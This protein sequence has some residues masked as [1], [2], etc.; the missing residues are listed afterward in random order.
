MDTLSLIRWFFCGIGVKFILSRI[1]GVFDRQIPGF[2]FVYTVSLGK[3]I[4]IDYVALFNYYLRIFVFLDGVFHLV[5]I[6]R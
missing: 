2:Y 3:R 6:Q 1:E 5:F 4:A